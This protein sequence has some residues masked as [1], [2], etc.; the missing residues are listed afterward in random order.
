MKLLWPKK[1]E[2][3]SRKRRERDWRQLNMK[4]RKLSLMLWKKRR[5]KEKGRSKRGNGKG[6]E[7]GSWKMKRGEQLNELRKDQVGEV[8]GKEEKSHP[9]T[10]VQEE[11]MIGRNELEVLGNLPVEE[12]GETGRRKRRESGIG[13]LM[14]GLLLEEMTRDHLC[15]GMMTGLPDEMMTGLEEMTRQG[16]TKAL[17]DGEEGMHLLNGMTHLPGETLA[18]GMHLQ[19]ET[20]HP[21]EILALL[22]EGISGK[23]TTGPLEETSETGMTVDLGEIS[24]TGMTAVLEGTLETEK[25]ADLEGT[26]ATVTV[27]REEIS[28]ATKIA[29][30]GEMSRTAVPPTGDATGPPRPLEKKETDLPRAEKIPQTEVAAAGGPRPGGIRCRPGVMNPE[31]DPLQDLRNLSPSEPHLNHLAKKM[32][33]GLPWPSVKLGVKRS[34]LPFEWS[35]TS[36]VF[37]ALSDGFK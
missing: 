4:R 27:P 22:G 1:N 7:R 24:E 26:L 12:D 25:I 16:G 32:T 8:K 3:D 6:L 28:D 33:V 36:N 31:T 15:G 21:K 19:E 18:E 13:E 23:G 20:M 17:G 30:P 37:S 34:F 14:T 29:V 11:Q 10:E 35:F 2:F 5:N 9:W